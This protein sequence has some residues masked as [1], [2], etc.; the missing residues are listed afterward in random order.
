[1]KKMV[2]MTVNLETLNWSDSNSMS[3]RLEQGLR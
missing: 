3:N 2:R 1:M